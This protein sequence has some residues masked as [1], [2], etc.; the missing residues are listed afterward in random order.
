MTVGEEAPETGKPKRALE[1]NPVEPDPNYQP[2]HAELSEADKVLQSRAE[3]IKASLVKGAEPHRVDED[4]KGDFQLGLLTMVRKGDLT[5][6][7]ARQAYERAGLSDSWRDLSHSNDEFMASLKG[8]WD[9]KMADAAQ[10]PVLARAIREQVATEQGERARTVDSLE[11]VPQNIRDAVR[12][13][14]ARVNGGANGGRNG[15]GNDGNGGNG[16][17]GTADAEWANLDHAVE[18]IARFENKAGGFHWGKKNRENYDRAMEEYDVLRQQAATHM[19]EE[20]AQQFPNMSQAELAQAVAVYTQQWDSKIS[21]KRKELAG[22]GFYGKLAEKWGGLSLPK[23]IAIGAAATVLVGAGVGLAAGGIGA[24]VGAGFAAKMGLRVAKT[25][26]N[27]DAANTESRRNL[28]RGRIENF[29]GKRMQA[30]YNTKWIK[31][32]RERMSKKREDSYNERLARIDERFQT[33]RSSA[34]QSVRGRAATERFAALRK[35]NLE[36]ERHDKRVRGGVAM[37][38]MAAGMLVGSTVAGVASESI[39][40][41]TP[42]AWLDDHIGIDRPS[43]NGAGDAASNPDMTDMGGNDPGEAPGAAFPDADGDGLPDYAD[44][45]YN[46]N[47]G[48]SLADIDQSGGG[49][50]NVDPNDFNADNIH[51]TYDDYVNSNGPNDWGFGS[52]YDM[53]SAETAYDSMWNGITNNPEQL[54][55]ALTGGNLGGLGGGLTPDQLASIGYTGDINDMNALGDWLHDTNNMANALNMLQDNMNGATFETVQLDTS[56]VSVYNYG[57]QPIFGDKGNVVD[58]TLIGHEVNGGVIDAVK[59]TMPNGTIMYF[60]ADCENLLV[61]E[62]PHDVPVVDNPEGTGTEGTGEEGTGTEGTGEEGTGTEG[63]GE[64]GTGTETEA[65]VTTEIQD[66]NTDTNVEVNEEPGSA[67]NPGGITES[68]AAAEQQAA[69]E[70]AETA[71]KQA[72]AEAQAEAQRQAEAAAVEAKAEA[73]RKAA[74]AAE[75]ARQ[76]AAAEAQRQAEQEAADARAEADRAA[77][78]AAAQQSHEQVTQTDVETAGA[79]GDVDTSTQDNTGGVNR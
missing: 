4:G 60:K 11:D 52:G 8:S 26:L 30:L 5:V 23:R 61:P 9:A 50:M 37:G 65:K 76:E 25:K 29:I 32:N 39:S 55:T 28:K 13:V 49:T 44:P 62:A 77:A 21:T 40:L 31:N 53:T 48:V 27:L 73:E 70:A 67:D 78:G 68:D 43:M 19:G 71:R 15:N 47:A 36:E 14:M 33:M 75:Q 41:P 59:I 46:G 16:E 7:E 35:L 12:V 42:G 74:E 57:M 54:A 79:N 1:G 6:D 63:T 10:D 66:Q 64:E 58:T 38:M 69:A 24:A 2:R 56:E 22:Q 17:P 34:D 72:E 18:Q 20:L 51:V 45:T 3:E